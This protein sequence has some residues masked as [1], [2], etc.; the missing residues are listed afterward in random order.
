MYT[1]TFKHYS[2]LKHLTLL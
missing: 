2:G 1:S